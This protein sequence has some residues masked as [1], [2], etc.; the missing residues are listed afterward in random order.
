MNL[1]SNVNINSTF[2]HE[3]QNLI[4]HLYVGLLVE[5]V[6]FFGNWYGNG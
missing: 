3:H 2:I 6:A 1:S 5:T 4:I